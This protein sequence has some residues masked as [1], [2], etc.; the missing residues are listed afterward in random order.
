MKR[1]TCLSLLPL[2]F[3]NHMKCKIK[4]YY[5]DCRLS[6]NHQSQILFYRTRNFVIQIQTRY[7]VVAYHLATYVKS[8]LPTHNVS[9]FTSLCREKKCWML[10][11]T[12]RNKNIDKKKFQLSGL[13]F[14]SDFFLEIFFQFEAKLKHINFI[15]T[16]IFRSGMKNKKRK[17][18]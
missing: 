8:I 15:K 16:F 13:I 14:Y 5:I 12:I 1:G 6:P 10:Q 3:Y 11:K 9:N 4:G 17:Q 18:L 2:K 7:I